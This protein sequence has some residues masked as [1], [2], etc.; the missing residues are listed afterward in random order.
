[1]RNVRNTA[2]LKI[3]VV[4]IILAVSSKIYSFE[5]V[6]SAHQ[7]TEKGVVLS[8]Y[9]IS[10]SRD[11]N[12][13]T[14]VGQ[15]APFQIGATTYIHTSP[16]VSETNFESTVSDVKVGFKVT[17][18]FQDKIYPWAR[19]SYGAST[20]DIPDVKGTNKFTGTSSWN[21]GAGVR[22]VILPGTIVTPAASIDFGA[23]YYRSFYSKLKMPDGSEKDVESG[24]INWIYQLSFLL[25][26]KYGK[27]EPYGAVKV[28]RNIVELKDEKSLSSVGGSKDGLGLTFGLK[29][30]ASSKASPAIELSFL[31]DRYFS[32]GVNIAF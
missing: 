15:I 8:I 31:N 3:S 6:N 27:F 1:M 2:R 11:V 28:S 24:L 14:K 21:V 10:G 30:N 32:A 13:T 23:G 4:G 12:F 20:L 29:F 25:S 7:I 17:T 18:N 5:I 9:G 26:K 16:T 22:K 19:I